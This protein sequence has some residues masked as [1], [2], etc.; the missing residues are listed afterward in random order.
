MKNLPAQIKNLPKHAQEIWI[1]A[2]NN[3]YK[4]YGEERARKIAWSAVKSKFKKVKDKWVS[5]KAK[6][7]VDLQNDLFQ[8]E[9]T[10]QKFD[11]KVGEKGRYIMGY[12]S[13]YDTDMQLERFTKPVLEKVRNKMLDSRHN[14]VVLFHNTKDVPIA[15]IVDAQVDD[16]GLFVTMKMNDAHP[17]SNEVFKSVREGFLDGMSIRGKAIDIELLY[18]DEIDSYIK[19]YKDFFYIETT[20]TGFPVNTEARVRGT[21]VAKSIEENIVL[22][23]GNNVTEE[24]VKKGDVTEPGSED[25]P[26]EFDELKS[27]VEALEKKLAETEKPDAD[28]ETKPADAEKAIKPPAGDAKDVVKAFDPDEFKE[29]MRAAFADEVKKAFS[30]DNL[31]DI[32][33]KLHAEP[34]AA[35]A[36]VKDDV[37][38]A[39]DLK[40]LT[41]DAAMRKAM[42]TAQERGLI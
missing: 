9:T 7:A 35:K 20:L 38:K 21:H 22:K 26:T 10:A 39:L 33:A 6:K 28:T 29:I 16:K 37:K 34:V 42:K 8:V 4:K 1:S 5:K 19:E 41:V 15:K 3:S 13:T 11:T 24:D 32:I 25:A 17:R 18:D 30:K 40:D 27:R 36:V 2:F 14:K 12:A 23:G 31:S